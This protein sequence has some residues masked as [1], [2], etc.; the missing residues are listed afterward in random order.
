MSAERP[1]EVAIVGGAVVGAALARA[2]RGA[3]IALIA[4]EPRSGGSALADEAAGSDS[5]IYA[6][7]PA[8][9]AFLARLGAW[10]G[11]PEARRTP[12]HAMRVY[13][14]DGSSLIEFD[15]YR[16]GCSELAWIVEDGML[17]DALWH[18]LE[19]Q[20]GIALFPGAS[21]ET[22]EIAETEARL[23]LKDGR[24]LR[25]MLV[26]GADGARSP[27]REH[28]GITSE[29]HAY[30]QTAV[31]ANF[32]CDSP[33]RNVAYQWFQGGQRD[34]AVLAFLP[35]P[36]NHVSMV[37]S[38]GDAEAARLLGLDPATLGREV[39]AASRN[40]LGELALV[41]PPRGFPLQRLVAQRM[42][43]PRVALVGDA[44]HVIHPLAGQGAN[45]G[46]QDASALAGTIAGR[47]P[48][49]D[50]GELRLLRRYERSRAEDILAMRAAVHGLFRLFDARSTRVAQLRN[51][52]LNFADRIPVLK[53]LLMRQAMG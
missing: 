38:V 43:V 5:R 41:T 47:E 12:V 4:Q 10:A 9:A 22:L 36:G 25:A 14:D 27:V 13:G 51:A 50:S 6:I 52:G 44:A 26:A 3:R 7:S 34:G 24:M 8:N 2:L 23:Q 40:V 39:A 49:R 30:G 46:L 48:G 19:S 20:D 29:R 32:A 42:V 15:A 1:F 37:W 11:I 45:L 53:N 16:S 31:V 35:L 28:S 33:H 18:G 17:Q 21:I